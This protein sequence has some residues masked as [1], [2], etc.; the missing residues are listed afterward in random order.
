MTQPVGER[1]WVTTMSTGG[2]IDLIHPTD[3]AHLKKDYLPLY[4]DAMRRKSAGVV[5]AGLLGH[6]AYFA[7]ITSLSTVLQVH[8]HTHERGRVMAL[9][10]MCFLGGTP[11]GAPLIGLMFFLGIYPK[12]VLERARQLLLEHG[13]QR[14]DDTCA[15]GGR[16][17]V[18]FVQRQP[19]GWSPTTDCPF[20]G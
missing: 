13:F 17:V 9:Y 11:V 2:P 7:V 1:G 14:R 5:H 16:V 20:A 10:F 8:L 15:Q 12:P 18:P 3:P 6:L 19:G 4:V